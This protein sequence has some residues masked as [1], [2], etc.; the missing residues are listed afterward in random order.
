M[1]PHRPE[2]LVIENIRALLYQ[3]RV[4]AKD[5]AMFCGH[6]P[7]WLSK[8]MAGERKVG[9]ADLPRIAEFFGLETYQL[10]QHGISDERRRFQRR[11]G[12]E[13]R[14]LADRRRGGHE[15]GDLHPSVGGRFR[16]PAAT[17]RDSTTRKV[18]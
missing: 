10:L 15:K 14:V 11:G 18:G 13:R 5:L 2:L 16:N 1:R 12:A 17:A 7:A 6:E 4:K 9:I 8:I 3:R